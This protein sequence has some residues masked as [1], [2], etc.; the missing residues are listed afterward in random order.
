MYIRYLHIH[1]HSLA[2]HENTL[3]FGDFPVGETRQI[4]FSLTNRG[5]QPVKFQWP[6]SL[7]GLSFSPATGHLHPATSK[8]VCVRFK[9]D[10]PV[11]LMREL[12]PGKIWKIKFKD[13]LTKVRKNFTS[14]C[15]S[16]KMLYV[17]F[18]WLTGMIVTR[19]CTGSL[20]PRPQLQVTTSHFH[21]LLKRR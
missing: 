7:P 8:D 16:P 15:V 13:P 17:Y 19:Q 4:S 12:V 18:R 20:S 3:D 10:R 14:H 2:L 6:S 21:H 9:S 5:S 1:V 11:T